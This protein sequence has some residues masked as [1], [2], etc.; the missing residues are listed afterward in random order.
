M[1]NRITTSIPTTSVLQPKLKF[2][3]RPYAPALNM[4][5]LGPE[6]KPLPGYSVFSTNLKV[7]T[8]LL[9]NNILHDRNN[10]QIV[11]SREGKTEIRRVSEI[12][13]VVLD[14]N[15]MDVSRDFVAEC[16]RRTG[17]VEAVCRHG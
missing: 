1:S 10:I 15:D 2:D 12:G 8:G 7:D 13:L 5:V 14:T 6:R 11:I 4:Q 16:F 17:T 3:W 9:I